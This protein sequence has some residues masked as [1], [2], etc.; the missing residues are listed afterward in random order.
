MA[1]WGRETENKAERPLIGIDA[2]RA[3]WSQ[4]TGVEW[5]AYHL[6]QELKTL[7]PD[8]Y[9]VRLYV[10]E[11]LRDGL[12]LGLPSHWEVKIMRHPPRLWTQL[13]LSLEMLVAPP[14]LLF[15][16]AH[17]MPIILARTSIITV[18]DVAFMADPG[19]YTPHGGF[20]L[21]FATWFATRFASRILTV[22]EF[23]KGEIMRF[24]GVAERRIGVTYLAYD[25]A[26]FKPVTDAAVRADVAKR[27]RI[28]GPYFLFVGRLERKKNIVAMLAAFHDCKKLWP[29]MARYKFVLVGKPGKGYAQEMQGA[30]ADVIEPGYVCPED[31]AALV[32][33]AEAL[34]FATKYEGFGIP[35]IEAMA[36]GTPVIASRTTS[37][38]EVC[39]DAALYVDPERADDIARALH[40]IVADPALRT[41]LSARGL[42]HAARFSWRRTAEQ[43]WGYMEELLRRP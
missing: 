31:M 20:Y 1:E 25:R 21:R 12:E 26:M 2:S 27:Y 8:T 28:D 17:A 34:V 38:P 42:A 5:Y 4:R 37:L 15:V 7:I 6:V 16:P 35:P 13:R 36:C 33:G 24:F 23:S 30:G 3:N 14:D 41:D 19:S 29:D 10:R 9:R 39:G 11:P 40:R 18:H 32:S 43:T 22:S